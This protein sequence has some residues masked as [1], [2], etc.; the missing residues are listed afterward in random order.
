M[1][2][3]AKQSCHSILKEP[4]Q[5]R[6]LATCA[7]CIMKNLFKPISKQVLAE[8]ASSPVVKRRHLR[9]C[10]TDR[11]SQR[12]L[13]NQGWL[14]SFFA[15]SEALMLP[16]PVWPYIPWRRSHVSDWWDVSE[17]PGSC[18]LW[19]GVCYS[20][21]LC[22]LGSVFWQPDPGRLLLS[23][24]EAVSSQAGLSP[25]MLGRCI[26]ARHLREPLSF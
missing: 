5:P 6:F 15:F 14:Q 4:E 3:N 10:S 1:L 2:T 18:V 11:R 25:E 8:A 24:V 17:L 21:V 22:I 13:E 9:V 26:S 12:G 23:L 7:G 16:P 20:G 19:T